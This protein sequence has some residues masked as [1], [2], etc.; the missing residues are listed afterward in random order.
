ME[1]LDAVKAPSSAP[2]PRRHRAS[3]SLLYSSMS[4]LPNP[5]VHIAVHKALHKAALA[6]T[7]IHLFIANL[8]SENMSKT[9]DLTYCDFFEKAI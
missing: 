8:S 9:E 1:R 7:I 4:S 6:K 3:V 2:T 5:C